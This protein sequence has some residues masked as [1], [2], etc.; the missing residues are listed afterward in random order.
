MRR[1]RNRL[2][3]LEPLGQGFLT[4]KVD[5]TQTFDVR[6]IRSVCPRFTE[7]ARKAN[8]PIIDLVSDIAR[9]KKAKRTAA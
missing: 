3:S 6:D 9:R 8:Q 4:G 2:R 1:T 5:V 7:E